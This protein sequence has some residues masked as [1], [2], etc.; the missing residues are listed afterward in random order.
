MADS[1]IGLIPTVVGAG[2]L[3][4]LTKEFLPE[5]LHEKHESLLSKVV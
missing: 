2:L 4:Y 1:L 3:I 5:G